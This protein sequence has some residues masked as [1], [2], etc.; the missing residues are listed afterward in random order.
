MRWH[1]IIA[2]VFAG[3]AL[4]SIAPPF[5]C[6]QQEL[7]DSLGS[8]APVADEALGTVGPLGDAGAHEMW[9]GAPA[10]CS[11][12]CTELKRTATVCRYAHPIW[13]LETLNILMQ[14][15][16]FFC[17]RVVPVAAILWLA[18]DI[19]P[20][21]DIELSDA[22][23][24]AMSW[25]EIVW[26]LTLYA[27][28]SSWVVI[29][30]TSVL[31]CVFIRCTALAPFAAVEKAPPLFLDHVEIVRR[32]GHPC[33]ISDPGGAIPHSDAPRRSPFLPVACALPRL[34][35]AGN[36]ADGC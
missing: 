12:R 16:L 18:R 30:V 23:F 31:D 11:G 32:G 21:D 19:I 13:L 36:R 9:E 29:V 33:A 22:A 20:A 14:V 4:P 34:R 26:R 2:E 25:F 24:G 17:L 27:F 35:S 6:G 3:E 7:S 1:G 15:G 8:E 28:I 5:G 10:R